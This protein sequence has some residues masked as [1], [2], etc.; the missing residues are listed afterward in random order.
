MMEKSQIKRLAIQAGFSERKQADGETDLNAY[1]YEFAMA[2]YQAG[3]ATAPEGWRLVPERPTAAM[4]DGLRVGSRTDVPG[5][6]LCE[7]R[8]AAALAKAPRCSR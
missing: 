5:N 8:W 7:I 3:Q 2:C 6:P 4:M 1:V